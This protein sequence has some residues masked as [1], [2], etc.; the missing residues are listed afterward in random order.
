LL[1]AYTLHRLLLQLGRPEEADNIKFPPGKKVRLR[2][3]EW[4]SAIADKVFFG[5]GNDLPTNRNRSKQPS[6]PMVPEE[7]EEVCEP[8]RWELLGDRGE[9][10]ETM[11]DFGDERQPTDDPYRGEED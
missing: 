8:T 10:Q 5:D 1:A 2:L 11:F 3:E 7:P 6:L 9:Q 4:W